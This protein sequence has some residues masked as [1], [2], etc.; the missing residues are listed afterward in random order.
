MRVYDIVDVATSEA[1][2]MRHSAD[3]I[4]RAALRRRRRRRGA[5][6][7]SGAAAM[8]AITVGVAIAV[9]SLGQP[10]ASP[11]IVGGPP[12]AV[13]AAAPGPLQVPADPFTFT[14]TGYDVGRF[15]VKAPLVASTAY[16]IAPV[17]QNG[18]NALSAYLVVYRPGAFNPDGLRDTR[19]LTVAGRPALLQE[20]TDIRFHKLL[21]WQYLDGAWATIE[22]YSSNPDDPSPADL[23]K[24]A[25][26]LPPAGPAPVKLPFRMSYVP[27]GFKPVVL[28]SHAMAGMDGI[29]AA[30][31]GDFGGA[32]FA[33]PAP[34][35]SGLTKPWPQSAGPSLPGSFELFVVPNANS[36]QQLRGGQR[37]PASPT[38][39]ATLCN[40]WTPDGKVNIQIAAENGALS[41]T[42]MIK[43]LNGITLA[44][45]ND[46]ATW[47]DTATAIPVTP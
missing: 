40:T 28:G 20:L 15:H 7:S 32:I 4:V 22:T 41:K 45:V 30:E 34:R 3:D 9:P 17:Y 18:S 24:I 11:K 37:P 13:Q 6:A 43:V 26:A 31:G 44:S 23:E 2:P 39:S 10:A 35:P 27:A 14:F 16:Q 47:F 5:V 21:A 33:K 36:N 1:P 25:L 29:A 12:K 8:A 38:C 42:E 19:Q 46:D